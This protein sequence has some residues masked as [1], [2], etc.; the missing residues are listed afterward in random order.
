MLLEVRIKGF[1]A[2]NTSSAII[3]YIYNINEAI[4][5][6]S[7][8]RGQHIIMDLPVADDKRRI[9]KNPLPRTNRFS[10]PGI[11][12]YIYIYIIY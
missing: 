11:Y 9:P 7:T 2:K 5:I 3:R 1:D 12:I 6:R 4:T 8:S 10:P